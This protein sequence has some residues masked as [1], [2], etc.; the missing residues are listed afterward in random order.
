MRSSCL[1]VQ[2]PYGWVSLCLA[3]QSSWGASHFPPATPEC[4][5]LR[6]TPR[7]ECVS[8]HTR[9]APN[10]IRDCAPLGCTPKCVWDTPLP[11][12]R[13]RPRHGAVGIFAA[14]VRTWAMAWWRM[15]LRCRCPDV[16]N[17]MGC[18]ETPPPASGR[19]PRH[20][21]VGIFA[22]GVRVRATPWGCGNLR[23]RCPAWTTPWPC[24][25]LRCRSSAVAHG[26]H[27][28]RSSTVRI[29]HGP[30][31]ELVEHA[32]DPGW[33]VHAIHWIHVSHLIRP[34]LIH[35]VHL[36]RIRTGSRQQNADPPPWASS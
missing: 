18:A 16:C 22:D 24:A 32:A 6:P 19:G 4:V 13:C 23:C 31:R 11:V 1:A 14:G 28:L 10:P 35:A 12:F 20:G 9:H 29:R 34:V 21:A 8:A 26:V 3:V 15:Q 17:A 36:I 30:W 2:Q 25:D 27:L 7:C 5:W 33:P